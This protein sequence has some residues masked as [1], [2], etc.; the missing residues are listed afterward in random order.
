M[1]I[2]AEHDAGLFDEPLP[3]SVLVV[4]LVVD[5]GAGVMMDNTWDPPI[6]SSTE[7]RDLTWKDVPIT[8]VGPVSPR[9]S[10]E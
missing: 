10:R 8:N 4:N 7:P 2:K 1:L 9:S 3:S 6:A 5:H